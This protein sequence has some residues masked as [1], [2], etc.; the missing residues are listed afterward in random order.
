MKMVDLEYIK[1]RDKII[2]EEEKRVKKEGLCMWKEIEDC[3]TRIV[4][5]Y[6]LKQ[7]YAEEIWHKYFK[8]ASNKAYYEDRDRI[9][10]LLK[11]REGF[12]NE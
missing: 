8:E 3:F 6:N 10:Q 2:D 4:K 11:I 12:R 7:E 1:Q 5:K 9:L